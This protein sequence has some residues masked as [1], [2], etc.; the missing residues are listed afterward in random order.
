VKN[1]LSSPKFIMGVVAVL[2]IVVIPLTIIQVQSQQDVRQ[3][4]EGVLW[5]TDQSASTAC[6]VDGSG[7]EIT[8]S[9]NNIEPHQ[10][11]MA[12]KV[13][14]KDQ[15]TGKSV[16]MGTITGGQ[17]K[18]SVIATGKIT[19]NAGTVTFSLAWADG[20]SG[21]DSRTAN[22]KAVTKCITPTATPSP[23]PTPT[24]GPSAS[25]TPVPSGQPTPTVCPTLPPVKNIKIDCPNCP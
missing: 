2:A 11:S 4:A 22:Y 20:H 23:S 18:T 7:V 24:V 6:A 13:I 19:L 14:A 5:A 12:M 17:N 10:S 25:P 16:D 8:V 1:L 3:R 15:Q 9:F 21:T